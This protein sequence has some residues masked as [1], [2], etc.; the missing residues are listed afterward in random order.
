MSCH[1]DH[2]CLMRGVP[3]AHWHL[4]TLPSGAISSPGACR[5][6]PMNHVSVLPPTQIDIELLLVVLLPSCS[7]NPWSLPCPGKSFNFQ[8]SRLG[9]AGWCDLLAA[10][11]H[12]CPA[13]LCRA[14]ARVACVSDCVFTHTHTPTHTPTHPPTQARMHG[15]VQ[16]H[17]CTRVTHPSSQAP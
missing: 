1:T 5:A 6:T 7:C 9:S 8:L 4:V 10:T 15:P 12:V 13:A 11:S 17:A 16:A 14:H 2:F 3:S